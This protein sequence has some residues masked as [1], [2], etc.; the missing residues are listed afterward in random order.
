[1]GQGR[2]PGRRGRVRLF[3]EHRGGRFARVAIVM[4]AWAG[5]GAAGTVVGSRAR[6]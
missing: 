1:M 6:V 2:F 5:D 4:G 3:L